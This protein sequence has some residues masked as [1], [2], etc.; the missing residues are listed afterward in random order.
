MSVLSSTSLLPAADAAV[1]LV[2]LP[3][4]SHAD[5]GAPRF[6]PAAL[7]QLQRRLGPSIRVLR[8]D[9]ASHPTVVR[10]FHAQQLPACVL[11][12]QGVELWRQP[13]LPDDDGAAAELL[14]K[15]AAP[16]GVSD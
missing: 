12:R 7:E 15:L 2:L 11:V 16:A 3:V 4:A 5:G 13:G 8:I 10:S 9:E 6:T 1:L 14:G